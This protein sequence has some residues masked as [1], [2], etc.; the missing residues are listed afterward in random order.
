M[1]AASIGLVVIL[2]AAMVGEA[3]AQVL[4]RRRVGV[5]L[6]NRI[7]EF[8]AQVTVDALG[9]GISKAFDEL[10]D[11]LV[12]QL[13]LQLY[14]QIEMDPAAK[15]RF[16][17]GRRPE[18]AQGS[19]VCFFLDESDKLAQRLKGEDFSLP[20]LEAIYLDHRG[21]DST[22]A[23]GKGTPWTSR[24]IYLAEN[25]KKGEAA[26]DNT[27][28]PSVK[29][30]ERHQLKD[31]RDK[32]PPNVHGTLVY[33]TIKAGQE[34]RKTVDFDYSRKQNQD[35]SLSAEWKLQNVQYDLPLPAAD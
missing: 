29:W 30:V 3:Q 24:P 20:V 28:G 4:P 16:T 27:T 26:Q 15:A 8:G 7:A 32:S 5:A 14:A 11:V 19:C 6:G 23:A 18:S 9:Q 31:P 35:G 33:R 12:L 13:A 22:K 17:S 34:M 21:I 10:G 25:A 2:M 1:R